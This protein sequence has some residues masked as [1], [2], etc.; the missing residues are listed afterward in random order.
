MDNAIE[1]LVSMYYL[2]KGFGKRVK[3]ASDIA[4]TSLGALMD[5]DGQSVTEINDEIIDN[6]LHGFQFQNIIQNET[7][8]RDRRR[9]TRSVFDCLHKALNIC[10]VIKH[11]II[12]SDLFQ[13]AGMNFCSIE[14]KMSD[15]CLNIMKYF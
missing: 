12:K 9:L 1:M 8:V 14:C 15:R 4:K 13:Q 11:L 10:Q 7:L 2:S 3:E 6:L 5:N